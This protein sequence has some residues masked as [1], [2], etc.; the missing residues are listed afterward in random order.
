MTQ[1]QDQQ[2]NA[3]NQDW[4]HKK[5]YGSTV[6]LAVVVICGLV[7]VTTGGDSRLS[8]IT[9]PVDGNLLRSGGGIT[10]DYSKLVES[11]EPCYDKFNAC[12]A[13]SACLKGQ[14]AE[15]QQCPPVMVEGP[16][17]C[18]HT[19]VNRS[20]PTVAGKALATCLYSN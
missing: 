16:S 10:K 18:A 8:T 12:V 11:G 20:T 1:E 6:L 4:K 7:A 2:N 15:C 9:S 14:L 3:P 5:G 19:C 13:D 17:D